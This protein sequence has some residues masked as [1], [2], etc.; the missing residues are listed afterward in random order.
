MHVYTQMATVATLVGWK[1]NKVNS[2]IL[3]SSILP[4]RQK[5]YANTA[6]PMLINNEE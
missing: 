5:G 4:H 3:P 2:P 6:Q 1:V